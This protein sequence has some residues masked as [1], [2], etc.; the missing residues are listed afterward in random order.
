MFIML[1]RWQ[2]ADDFPHGNHK[3]QRHDNS[4]GNE[5]DGFKRDICFPFV[6]VLTMTRLQSE[7]TQ[8][9]AE[10]T[11]ISPIQQRFQSARQLS[12]TPQHAIGHV[13]LTVPSR[14]ID[15]LTAGAGV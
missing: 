10:K 4:K 7:I 14:Q 8:F 3:P 6:I 9:D 11:T 13:R 15:L 5:K 2:I 1:V 12:S